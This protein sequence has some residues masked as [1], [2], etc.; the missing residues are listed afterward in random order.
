MFPQ[1]M[2]FWFCIKTAQ[3][4]LKS[5]FFRVTYCN[6]SSF[7]KEYY[8]PDSDTYFSVCCCPLIYKGGS[9]RT[10]LIVHILRVFLYVFCGS[11]NTCLF[12]LFS[13]LPLY[14]P[15]LLPR[16]NLFQIFQLIFKLLPCS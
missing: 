11:N 8:S 15:F 14:I 12:L 10:V 1:I 2:T 7:C 9:K 13:Y 6:K 3:I 5:L 4:S 16:G